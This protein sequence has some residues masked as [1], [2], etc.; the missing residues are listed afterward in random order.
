MSFV[1]A[2]EGISLVW[3]TFL[4]NNYPLFIGRVQQEKI[5]TARF[6]LTEADIR[7][8]DFLRPHYIEKFGNFFYLNRIDKYRIDQSTQC[9][10]V[11]L[12]FGF[13]GNEVASWSS[14]TY[15]E[16][17]SLRN[18]ILRA[19]EE[20]TGTAFG[21]SNDFEVQ[22]NEIYRISYDLN[23]FAVFGMNFNAQRTG[24]QDFVADGDVIFQNVLSGNDFGNY[25]NLTGAYTFDAPYTGIFSTSGIITDD[26]GAGGGSTISLES[27]LQGTLD[28]LVIAN[29]TTVAFDLE[30]QGSFAINEVVTVMVTTSMA[31]VAS[32][33]NF[34]FAYLSG[35]VPALIS[36][37]SA[38]IF[39]GATPASTSRVLTQGP[40]NDELIVNTSGQAKLRLTTDDAVDYSIT[41][42]L[43]KQSAG[44]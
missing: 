26:P 40:N 17:N 11:S 38:Q 16:F 43:E 1:D 23:F 32:G 33:A 27:D 25:N 31:S 7:E 44:N 4:T 5:L 34:S 30:F 42:R 22:E 2:P 28:S 39:I 19:F 3:D 20:A 12:H 24:Q 13:G 9:T 37:V 21:E 6:N 18:N 29:N 8:L 14:T 36:D 41:V 35:S 10:L 15:D